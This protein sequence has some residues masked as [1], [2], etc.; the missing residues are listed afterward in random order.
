MKFILGVLIGLILAIAIA[1]GA[2]HFAF[3]DLSDIGERDKSKDI[4]QVFDLRDFDRIDIGGVYEFDVTVGGD[5]SVEISGSPEEMAIVEARVEDGELYLGQDR[6]DHGKRRWRNQ[7][8]T[9]TISLPSLIGI[10]AS[11]VSEGNVT[12]IAA[13]NFS[14]RLSGVGD[15]DLEGTCGQLVARVSG[16][17]DL[18]ARKLECDGV[19]V[20]V[21]GIGD[22]KVYASDE[23]DAAVSGIGAIKI[24]GSPETVDKSGTFLSSIS[25]E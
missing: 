7:G 21:S 1:A 16:V 2:A 15:L 19:N 11:G 12:G 5:F 22:A 6:P 8:L 4:S 13:D 23:A 20:R 25:V 24:Y 17:G 14:A 18:N 3:G 9:A 10:D